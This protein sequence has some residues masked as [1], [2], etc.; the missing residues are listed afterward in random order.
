MKLQTRQ[1]LLASTLFIG[2]AMFATPAFAQDAQEPEATA[3]IGDSAA[4]LCAENPNAPDCANDGGAIVVTGSRIASPTLDSASPLQVIDAQEISESGVTNVQEVL[5]ENPAMGTP[6]FSRTNSNFLTSGAGVATIDLHNLGTAR[7]LVL[8]NGHRTVAGLPGGST[9]DFNT[10]PAEFIERIDV[11]TG[12]ASSIY[13]SDAVAGVV[14]IIYRRNFEGLKLTGQAGISGQGDD[15]R[16]QLGLMIGSNFADGRGNVT[17]YLGYTKEEGVFSGNRRRTWLDQN[18]CFAV[19]TNQGGCAT[20]VNTNGDNTDLFTP[21]APFLSGF[22]PGGTITFGPAGAL[23]QRNRTIN[24]DGALLIVNTNGLVHNDDGAPGTAAPIDVGFQGFER[25]TDQDPCHP[26]L[27]AATGYNRS[28]LR[29]IAVPVERYLVAL[30]GNFEVTDHINAFMEGNFAKSQSTTLIEP[31]AFQT[32]GVNGTAPNACLPAIT[33]P[34]NPPA[35]V[36]PAIPQTICG[37]FHPIETRLPNGTIVRNP[38]V[39]DEI[40]NYAV[41]RTFDGLKDVSF[42]RRLTD[43]GPRTYTADRQTFRLMAGLEGDIFGDWRWDT[44]FGF[45]QTVESQVGSG[46]VNLNSFTSALEVIPG[47]N[48]PQCASALA[49]SQGCAPANIFGGPG[50]ISPAARLYIQASQTRNVRVEQTVAGANIAG[51]LFELPGGPIGLAAGVEYRKENSRSVNDPLTQAG[52]NGGNALLPTFGTFNVKEAY[53][54]IR[55]PLIS[56]SFIHELSLRAAGRVSDYTTIGNVFSWNVGAE[57]APIKDVRFRVVRARATRAPNINE[58]FGGRSQT[59]PTGLLDPCAGVTAATA[60]A[61]ATNCRNAAGVNAN[62]ALNGAFTLN[63]ADLQGISGFQGGTP[64]LFEESADTWTAGV[65]INPTSIRPLRN[66]VITADFYD[67]QIKDAIFATGRQT[68][69]NRCYQDNDPVSCALITRRAAAEGPNSAGSLQ[70]IN[71]F[72]DNTGGLNT[73]GIDT[74]FAWRQRLSDW[75]MGDGTLALRGA[76]SHVFRLNSQSSPSAPV[77]PINGEIGAPKDKANASVTYE[78]RNWGLTVRANYIGEV[79]TDNG[80]SGFNA[81]ADG[82]EDFRIGSVIYIDTQIRFRPAD[83]YEFY[84]GVDNLFNRAPPPIISGI[85]GSNTGA[86]TDASTYDPIGRSFYAGARLK[87]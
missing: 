84:L 25:C 30:R 86:E 74:T 46:Q 47:P 31:F 78:E 8:I 17:A 56:E 28:A 72:S 21:Y 18:A 82:S 19:A 69:L 4:T 1:R 13:G 53:G 35:A 5:L 29:T 27:A 10:I 38:F 75:G 68:I 60:T 79:F 81:G 16:Y 11:L 42:T 50:S 66:L 6:T 41:D 48:G 12:G 64:T 9:V 26:S 37:G 70:F 77:D 58:L 55:I 7:T 85:P 57:F 43:F 83:E 22:N 87:F 52:L 40:Y 49:V 62:I 51:S 61:T 39:P 59:F 33:S 23:T 54:E 2:A 71:T 76:Y 63:Q 36:R 3:E 14:N 20:A 67:I 80:F 65:V 24:A 44:Y 73:R 45:G 32:S 15:Q 34:P